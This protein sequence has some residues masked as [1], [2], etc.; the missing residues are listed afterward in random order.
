MTSS[1]QWQTLEN[2]KL[3]YLADFLTQ[4]EADTLYQELYRG[5]AWRQESITL[6]GRCVLQPR[7]QT[8]FSERPYKYSG[9]QLQPKAIP[10]SIHS[11][12]TQCEQVCE[13]KFNSVLL[14]LYRDGQ[15]YMG[16]HQDN[17]KELGHW[18]VIASIS[19]GAERKFSLKHKNNQQKIDYQ[20]N[21]GSLLIM[22]G[23]LQ[24]YWKHALPKST[25]ITQPRINLTFRYIK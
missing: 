17:E 16:W 21:H 9:L 25:R 15:D 12:K 19:L 20:L 1:P 4:Q 11:L 14:N 24:H 13:Q 10:P 6:F 7:L 22:V 2:G 8:W 23:E 18:P 3:A 5:I